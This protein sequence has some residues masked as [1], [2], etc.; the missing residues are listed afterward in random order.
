MIDENI[1][2]IVTA[3]SFMTRSPRRP[4]CHGTNGIMKLAKATATKSAYALMRSLIVSRPILGFDSCFWP[5]LLSGESRPRLTRRRGAGVVHG[6]RRLRQRMGG[7]ARE[8]LGPEVVEAR[9]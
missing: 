3:V 1:A 7:S 8:E 9:A 4:A 2:A 5:G 6:E